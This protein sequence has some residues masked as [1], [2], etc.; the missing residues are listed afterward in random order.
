MA[1]GG[2]FLLRFAILPCLALTEQGEASEAQEALLPQPFLRWASGEPGF[3]PVWNS[4]VVVVVVEVAVS[5]GF[6]RVL[7]QQAMSID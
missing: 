6:I 3:S 7:A 2:A 4:V 5:S 1:G